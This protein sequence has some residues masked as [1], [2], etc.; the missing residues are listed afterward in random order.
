MAPVAA[1]LG[2]LIG[3]KVTLAPAVVGEEVS[4]VLEGVALAVGI[5]RAGAAHLTRL[6]AALPASAVAT[7]AG[8]RHAVRL[9]HGSAVDFAAVANRQ[10]L[11]PV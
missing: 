4:S 3:A 1:R 11:A 9:L 2:E 8:A 10:E 5:R 6:A 7:T